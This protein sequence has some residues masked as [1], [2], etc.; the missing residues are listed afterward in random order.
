MRW[1]RTS[2][3]LVEGDRRRSGPPLRQAAFGQ[4]VEIDVIQGGDQ[5][6]RLGGGE[7]FLVVCER[8]A[9][10]RHFAGLGRLDAGHR[11]LDD[12]AFPRRHA[13]LTGPRKEDLRVR[14]SLREVAAGD[15]GVE[16]LEE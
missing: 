10:G 14:L 8:E 11:V 1:W 13:E 9:E 4:R 15:V 3:R 12:E 5:H 7:E 6:I 16:E 2:T